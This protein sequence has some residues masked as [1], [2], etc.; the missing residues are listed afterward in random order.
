MSE[1]TRTPLIPFPLLRSIF[2]R[3]MLALLIMVLTNGGYVALAHNPPVYVSGYETFLGIDC[4]LAG[5]P[6]TCGV[7]FAGWIGGDGPVPGGWE[8]FPGDFQG[9]WNSR[10]NYVGKA[11]FG[12]TVVILSGRYQISFLDGH[13]LSGSVINGTVQWPVNEFVDLGC[14]AGVALLDIRLNRSQKF[15]GCLHDLPVAS[16]IPPMVWGV[17]SN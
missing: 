9:L 8:P 4:T 5:Q 14:G 7:T 17:F 15:Q 12:S 6:A 13:S 10:V 1:K 2:S 16:V 11:G 3:M